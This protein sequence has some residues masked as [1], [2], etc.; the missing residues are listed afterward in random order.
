MSSRAASPRVLVLAA[1]VAAHAGAL[2]V[3]LAETRTRLVRGEAEASPLLVML[4]APRERQAPTASTGAAIRPRAPRFSPPEGAVPAIPPLVIPAAPGATIDWAAQATASAAR[5]IESDEQRARQGRAFAQQ[6][7][8]MF[9]APSK[10]HEFRW[11]YASTHRVEAVAGLGTVIHLNDQCVL[12]LFAII[13]MLGCAVDK[14]PVR[15]DLF[16]HMHDPD[17]A[18]QP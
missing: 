10:R 14:P 18:P 16:E 12:V 11:D 3:L 8:P 6:P 7:N 15:G 2:L 9:A 13:P 1:V 4:L 5:Q 17:P